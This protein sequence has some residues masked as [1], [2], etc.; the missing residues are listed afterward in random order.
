MPAF[1]ELYALPALYV[2]CRLGG[3]AVFGPILGS[4]AV[5]MK[6]RALLTVVLAGACAPLVI[7]LLDTGA[8]AAPAGAFPGLATLAIVVGGEVAIGAVIGLM[9]S[10]PLIA[11]QV[12]GL[13][14]GQ[15]LGLGFGRFYLPAMDDE[16]DALEQMCFLFALVLF[17]SIGGLEQMVLAAVESYR[18]LAPGSLGT[19]AVAGAT[20]LLVG[21]LGGA[22]ELGLRVAA[23]VLA[24]VALESVAL[25]FVGRTL[26]AL[27]VLSIGFALR[28]AAGVAV[29][30][31]GVGVVGMA[32]DGF[33]DEALD[34]MRLWATGGAG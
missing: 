15:Q 28:I 23:P 14:C 26:P 7:G 4:Q 34:V 32:I 1:F 12:G 25:G 19:G 6:A 22:L 8:A 24:I 20:E 16:G 13:L 2:L 29:L 5:P 3:V 30:A 10:I 21:L 9:A 27:N 31:L 11:A 17:I 18:W 33:V